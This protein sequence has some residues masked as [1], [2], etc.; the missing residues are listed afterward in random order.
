[1]SLK[2]IHGLSRADFQRLSKMMI[3]SIGLYLLKGNSVLLSLLWVW[4]VIILWFSNLTAFKD[5]IDMSRP[6]ASSSMVPSA[7]TSAPAAVSAPVYFAAGS[8]R[9]LI[10]TA[11]G[12]RKQLILLKLIE[13]LLM[14]L[15]GGVRSTLLTTWERFSLLI[16]MLLQLKER[17]RGKGRERK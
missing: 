16:R 2:K 15:F 1:M 8:M 11:L 9:D 12:I 10:V 3:Q 13:L 7:F 4:H 6:S 14:L 17:E 5:D